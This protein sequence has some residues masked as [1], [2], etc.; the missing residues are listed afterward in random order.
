M[1]TIHQISPI[2]DR[3]SQVLLLGTMPSP[4]S[5]EAG[6]FFSH[7]QNKMWRILSALFHEPLPTT[8]AQKTDLLLR[9]HLAMWDVL[10]SC[11]IDGADD[12]SIKSPTPNDLDL[13]Y[14]AAHLRAVFT[15]GGKAAQLFQRFFPERESIPL[16]STSP[17]NCRFYDFD[18]LQAA[19]SVI[20]EYLS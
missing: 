20:L 14:G 19:Y 8:N 10:H 2:F 13:I 6:F 3:H 9:H 18:K 16:P 1:K 4:K 5:R 7:P 17:A 11:E 12:A 15:T